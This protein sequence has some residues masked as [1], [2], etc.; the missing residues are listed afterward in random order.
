MNS[1]CF[2]Y[3]LLSKPEIIQMQHSEQQN[4]SLS[5]SL[6]L[7]LSV[8]VSL[9]LCLSVSVS[10]TEQKTSRYVM[11]TGKTGASD[12]KL[13][14]HRRLK[15]LD[16]V[17]LTPGSRYRSNT[18]CWCLGLKNVISWQCVRLKKK[19]SP[20]NVTSLSLAAIMVRRVS[21]ILG[22]LYHSDK[23]CWFFYFNKIPLLEMSHLSPFT[24]KV[25]MFVKTA[26]SATML[27][28]VICVIFIFSSS[29][30]QFAHSLVSST[31]YHPGVLLSI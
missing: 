19:K 6:C 4:C 14:H 31:E 26:V 1:F 22:P 11:V 9:C 15:W 21:H 20:V 29:V 25:W 10:L 12:V 5:L 16:A 3:T 17:S 7:C 18:W 23:W 2:L 13:T 8:S 27:S 28:I 30:V 24:S